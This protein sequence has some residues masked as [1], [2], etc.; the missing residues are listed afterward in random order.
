MVQSVG[1]RREILRKIYEV[2]C[3]PHD[4][5]KQDDMQVIVITIIMIMVLSV[6]VVTV[7]DNKNNNIIIITTKTTTTSIYSKGKIQMLTI[8][9]ISLITVHITPIVT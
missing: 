9:I 7:A 4:I 3:L 1:Y 6:I 8:L 2:E 5:H